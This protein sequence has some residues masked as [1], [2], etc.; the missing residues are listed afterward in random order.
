MHL[1]WIALSLALVT[2]TPMAARQSSA[3]D[4]RARLAEETDVALF[5]CIPTKEQWVNACDVGVTASWDGTRPG[6]KKKQ[7]TYNP[8][9][10]WVLVE[11]RISRKSENNG[12]Y[13]INT[14]AKGLQ[15]ISKEDLRDSYESLLDSSGSWMEVYGGKMRIEERQKAHTRLLEQYSTNENTLIVKVAAKA[16]GLP[17][18]RKRGW[19]K[20]KVKARLL[21]IGSPQV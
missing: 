1:I 21:C 15:L 19:M 8:P 6:S 9:P 20:L 12:S 14:L 17:I 7:C 5:G 2:A 13:S 11:H 18:D 4:E 3:S 10:G 16:H